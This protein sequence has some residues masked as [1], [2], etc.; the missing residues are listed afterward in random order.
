MAI[1]EGIRE[2]FRISETRNTGLPHVFPKTRVVK[3]TRKSEKEK[4]ETSKKRSKE[5]KSAQI[6]V[7][8]TKRVDIRV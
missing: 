8:G 4:E 5:K 2:L 7:D 3:R 1:D 6:P